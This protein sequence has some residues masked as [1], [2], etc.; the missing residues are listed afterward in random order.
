MT[1]GDAVEIELMDSKSG[2]T[3]RD[4][5]QHAP[6]DRWH[7][8]QVD[9]PIKPLN[10]GMP[11]SVDAIHFVVNSDKAVLLIDDLLLYEPTIEPT[12]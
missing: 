10:P 6:S 12:D 5:I 4:S 2:K 9:F 7:E 1:G 11:E 8:A 3:R